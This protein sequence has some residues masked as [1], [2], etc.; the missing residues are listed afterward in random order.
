MKV[1]T[2]GVEKAVKCPDCEKVNC[3]CDSERENWEER[4]RTKPE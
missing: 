4:E 1:I 3:I 2:E